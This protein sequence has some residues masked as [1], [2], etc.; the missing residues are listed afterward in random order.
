MYNTFDLVAN[1]QEFNLFCIAVGYCIIYIVLY[2]ELNID[3]K[4]IG[5]NL[6]IFINILIKLSIMP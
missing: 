1:L 6:F 4:T 3:I 5:I 2:V